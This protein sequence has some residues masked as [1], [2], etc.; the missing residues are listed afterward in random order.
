MKLAIGTVQFGLPYGIANKAGQVSFDEVV[1]ILKYAKHIGVDTIDTAV[2]YGNSES[3]LG[4]AGV[5][6]FKV[7]TKLPRIPDTVDNAGW[8]IR[9]QLSESMSR[10]KIEKIYGIL[11]HQPEQLFGIHGNALVETLKYLKAEKKVE[12]IGVS[13]YS[14]NELGPILN[15]LQCDLI[16]APF[17]LLDQ[18]LLRTGWLSRLHAAGIEI[19]TRSTFLQGLLL[20]PKSEVP[21]KFQAWQNLWDKWDAWLS[22]ASVP[23]IQACLSFSLSFPEISRVVV[24]VD[25]LDHLQQIDWACKGATNEFP[26]NF[27]C[28]DERLISPVNWN[29]L[30]IS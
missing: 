17:S 16:Q 7:V 5:E 12:K 4:K 29:K 6:Y 2:S 9:E 15:V 23:A 8:W 26:A 3:C 10:L 20:M 18:R 27:A 25:G 1:S 28:E 24:G 19:H 22:T 21:L 30:E 11:L 13:I 14:P